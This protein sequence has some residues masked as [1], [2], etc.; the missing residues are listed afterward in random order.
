MSEPE[1][2]QLIPTAARLSSQAAFV[3]KSCCP[4]R[5]IRHKRTLGLNGARDKSSTSSPL[6]INFARP[7]RVPARPAMW[8]AFSRA[9]RFARPRMQRAEGRASSGEVSFA[10]LVC[11]VPRP[12]WD[13][14][15]P[16]HA[17]YKTQHGHG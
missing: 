3:L 8:I 2:R 1:T 13:Y 4:A 16:T 10:R 5:A 7:P 17:N 11:F 14:S 9:L 12:T 15:V 6:A